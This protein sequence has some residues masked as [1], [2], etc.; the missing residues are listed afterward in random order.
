MLNRI[1]KQVNFMENNPEISAIGANYE[2]LGKKLRRKIKSKYYMPEEIKI[3][4]LFSNPIAN[5]SAMIR[6]SF[7]DKKNL[8]YNINY[9]VAQDYDLWLQISKFGKIAILPDYL[10]KYKSVIQTFQESLSKKLGGR[11]KLII[12]S[13]HKDGLEYYGFNLNEKELSV[14][15]EFYSDNQIKKYDINFIKKILN[16]IETLVE[17]NKS[18]CIFDK[19][20]FKKYF[21]NHL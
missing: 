7:L 8:K 15:N 2:L 12:D 10:I 9:F 21:L 4:L 5:P 1:E 6:K 18:K 16:L 17:I 20:L 14:F 19:T 13:I 3:K 11:R